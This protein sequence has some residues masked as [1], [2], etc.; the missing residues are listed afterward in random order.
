MKSAVSHS[1]LKRI[2]KQRPAISQCKGW[3]V[4]AVFFLSLLSLPVVAG[5]TGATGNL[6][7]GLL[8][9]FDGSFHTLDEYTGKGQWTVVMIWAS[10]CH[11]CNVEA[12]QYVKFHQAHKDTDAR[13]LGIS[14][15]GMEKKQ[16]AEKFIERHEVTFSNLIETPE[17]VEALY[18]SLTGQAFVGT[19][20]FLIYSP[21]GE[22]R[23]AQVGAVPTHIIESFIEKESGKE[24]TKKKY[25]VE[26]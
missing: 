3:L 24:S 4:I 12:K 2:V 26:R 17:K 5:V 7:T 21:T 1:R 25:K 18:S 10:D 11:A 13:I 6:S 16:E 23:A 14:M 9:D 15:D 20:T 22:L 8:K 19:P